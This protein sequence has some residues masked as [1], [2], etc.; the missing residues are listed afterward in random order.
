MIVA[1]GDCVKFWTNQTGLKPVFG[2]V[3]EAELRYGSTYATIKP[4]G[5]DKLVYLFYGAIWGFAPIDEYI[6]PWSP[7][8]MG[9]LKSRAVSQQN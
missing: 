7:Q 3:Q 5:S 4:D 8:A 9:R 6:H 2:T 1:S